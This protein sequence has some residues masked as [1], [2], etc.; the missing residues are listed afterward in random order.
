M[1][2]KQDIITIRKMTEDDLPSV[3]YVDSSISGKGRVTSW[4]FSFE[5][6]WSVYGSKAI[7]YV[8][9][10]NGKVTGFISGYIEKEERSKHLMMKPHETGDIRQDEKIG[11]IEMMGIRPDAWHKG[12]GTRLLDAFQAECKK[13]NARMR[14]VF[15]NNDADL[16][17]Y[18]ENMGF[19]PPE[20][21]TLE[22]NL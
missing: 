22:K 13:Q 7:C 10:L 8:A 17:N 14:V 4:P 20:F 11:W 2:E 18:F 16:R 12:I 21:I 15:K 19:K 6:Y 3:T 9:E 1:T 5:L